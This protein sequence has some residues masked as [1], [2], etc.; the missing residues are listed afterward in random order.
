MAKNLAADL[1][2]KTMYLQFVN[3]AKIQYE[4]LAKKV[5]RLA[6]SK[7]DCYQ[8]LIPRKESIATNYKLNLDDF[9]IEIA[10]QTYNPELALEKKVLKLLKSN[11]YEDRQDIIQLA[12]WCSIIKNEYN[13]CNELRICKKKA[14]LT[15]NDYKQYLFDYYNKVHQILLNGDAYKFSFGIGTI[16]FKRFKF[17]E[18]Y[19]TIDY[20]ATKKRKQELID[21]GYIP[22]KKC[23]DMTAQSEG[24]EYN[25]IPYVVYKN[26]TYGYKLVFENS[27]FGKEKKLYDFKP[28]KYINAKYRGYTY[29]QII[30][31]FCKTEEDIAKL[32]VDI[33]TKLS[34]L[35][36]A[37]PGTSLR[38]IRK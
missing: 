31:Y 21:A 1:D 16:Y 10:N 13:T 11:K 24:K 18:E 28:V 30:K 12:K 34:L 9:V 20:A 14:M 8:Y 35:L 23:D 5:E 3:K 33:R 27:L 26:D 7:E 15:F 2:T 36:I 38:F 29:E 25:G 4:R 6:K 17:S 19:K 32:Q 37:N 22:Y